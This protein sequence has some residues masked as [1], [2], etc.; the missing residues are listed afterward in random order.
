METVEQSGQEISILKDNVDLISDRIQ[1]LN[2]MANQIGEVSELVSHIANQTDM[3]ALNAS[4]EAVRAGDRGKGFAVVAAEIR[5]LAD[6]SKESATKIRTLVTDVRES[7]Q[8]TATITREGTQTADAW[9]GVAEKTVE[10]FKEVS[11]L[12]SGVVESARQVFRSSEE[13][14]SATSQIALAMNNLNEE[15]KQTAREITETKES[16]QQLQ[17]VVKTLKAIVSQQ[18]D[19]NEN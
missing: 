19:A 18:R 10:S 4:V 1:K 9:V 3:L 12:L 2:E 5:K 16:V 13:Q 11:Q 6:R 7:V 14:A 15:A 8:N 17:D